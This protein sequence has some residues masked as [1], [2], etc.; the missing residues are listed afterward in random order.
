MAYQAVRS[1]WTSILNLTEP[2]CIGLLAHM[3]IST[4]T[5]TSS[6]YVAQLVRQYPTRAQAP[7]LRDG[8]NCKQKATKKKRIG[9][10]DARLDLFKALLKFGRR[11]VRCPCCSCTEWVVAWIDMEQEGSQSHVLCAQTCPRSAQISQSQ[12][13][14]FIR[15]G[16]ILK[17][18]QLKASKYFVTWY[19]RRTSSAQGDA[20]PDCSLLG[21][22][23]THTHVQTKL[24]SNLHYKTLFYVIIQMNYWTQSK[25]TPERRSLFRA[26]SFNLCGLSWFK[27]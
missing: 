16:H 1:I 14:D 25:Q 19:L 13:V 5:S 15:S 17:Y 8:C 4:C 6:R 26:C 12:Q 10:I 21:L 7:S 27:S 3:H 23:V 24:Y 20:R 2:L 18:N 22:P 9:T 11:F